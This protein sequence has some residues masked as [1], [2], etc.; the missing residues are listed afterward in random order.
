[1]VIIFSF[2]AHTDKRSRKE[3]KG[4]GK[5]G[6]LRTYVYFLT[7]TPFPPLL[8]FSSPFFLYIQ[9]IL[10]SNIASS[11]HRK[12]QGRSYLVVIRRRIKASFREPTC[13]CEET[14]TAFAFTALCEVVLW[15]E[16]GDD[17]GEEEDCEDE[18]E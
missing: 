3:N 14:K 2:F 8:R 1:M 17:L 7:H 12:E 16:D 13:I 4:Q 6:S 9:C 5:S 18:V 10:H 15:P 11:I